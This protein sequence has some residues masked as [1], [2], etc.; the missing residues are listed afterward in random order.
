MKR[1]SGKEKSAKFSLHPNGLHSDHPGPPQ[2]GP[3]PPGPPHP[4][5]PHARTPPAPPPPGP[6]QH[7][8]LLLLVLKRYFEMILSKFFVYFHGMVLSAKRREGKCKNGKPRK[9]CKCA[10]CT[11][12]D[13]SCFLAIRLGPKTSV[14]E[15]HVSVKSTVAG[16]DVTNC[17]VP[18]ERRRHP[19]PATRRTPRYTTQHH[20]AP[21]TRY[22]F[23]KYK[24][25]DNNNLIDSSQFTWF[26]VGQLQV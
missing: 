23:N 14:Y 17:A 21:R 11:V 24:D 10:L 13:A 18:A 25:I 16:C 4:R 5:R 6:T 22:F 19:R 12:D 7:G 8:P 26:F 2:P 1:G 20:T 15:K 9:T 3:P